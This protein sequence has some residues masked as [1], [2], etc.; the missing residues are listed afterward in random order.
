MAEKSHGWKEVICARCKLKE[1]SEEEG[2]KKLPV[3]FKINCGF[4]KKIK[5][6]GKSSLIFAESW[7]EV[8]TKMHKYLNN[9]KNPDMKSISLSA[10]EI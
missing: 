10:R 5:F 7:R 4:D 1:K 3:Y 9:R 8:S 6:E 2:K